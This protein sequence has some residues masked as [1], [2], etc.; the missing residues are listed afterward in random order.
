MEMD[1]IW[2]AILINCYLRK[3]VICTVEF[4]QM[5]SKGRIFSYAARLRNIHK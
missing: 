1:Q 5:K 2:E 4:P 3:F